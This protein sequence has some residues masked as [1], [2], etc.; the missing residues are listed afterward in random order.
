MDIQMPV[1][2]GVAATKRIRA[3]PH[4]DQR[5]PD[6]RHD[7]QRVAAASEVVSRRGH[8]RSRRQADRARASST[9]T[10]DAGCRDQRATGRD[11][12]PN[13]SN[14]DKSR[15]RRIRRSSSAP[16]RRSASPRNS[17]TSSPKPSNST[18]PWPKRSAAAHALVNCAGV[19]GFEGLVAAC[20]AVE[21]VSPDG[22]DQQHAAVMKSVASNRRRD[23]RLSANNCRNC[24]SW[25]SG[26][27]ATNPD[28]WRRLGEPRSTEFAAS[29]KERRRECMPENDRA[30]ASGPVFGL[31][32]D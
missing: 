32:R 15:V 12:G 19:L 5:H 3:M 30:G 16:K 22:L 20:R 29:P 24:T 25:R 13:S 27:S 9:T 1:M 8:E 21:F 2:D 28:R 4:S 7:R 31:G 6:H 11:V 18:A 26:E 10:F 17:S 14:F 23:R